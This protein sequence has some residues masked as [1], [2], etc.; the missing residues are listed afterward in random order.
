MARDGAKKP[1]ADQD[2]AAA[3]IS[4]KVIREDPADLVEV[5]PE[6]DALEIDFED[7]FGDG[8]ESVIVELIRLDPKFYAGQRV[9]GFLCHLPP[10]STKDTIRELYGGGQFRIIKKG[11]GGKIIASRG[12]AIAGV[13]FLPSTP[14]G[15]TDPAAADSGS[16]A[17]AHAPV[18]T[19]EGI[20][21]GIENAEFIRMAQQ[22]ALIRAA[23]PDPNADLIK[24]LLNRPAAAPQQDLVALAGQIIG[25]VNQF[26]EI[27][28][29]AAAG[30][31]GSGGA[32][33]MDVLKEGVAAFGAYMKAQGSRPAPVMS[34][35]ELGAPPRPLPAPAPVLLPNPEPPAAASE[36][37]TPKMSIQEFVNSA[38]I[39]LCNGYVMKKTPAEVVSALN[40]SIPL[41]VSA[42]AAFLEPQKD[43]FK[44]LCETNLSDDF[45]ENPELADRFPE[46][47]EQVFSG[48]IGSEKKD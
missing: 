1:A 36:S 14:G 25:L 12:V 33:L 2:P 9:G 48:F 13:P 28:P 6:S 18:L 27:M 16:P 35:P 23:F 19:K 41:P 21:I 15:R 7:L 8:S 11:I 38:I 45:F 24:A 22:L 47:F 43:A 39:V 5:D 46:F 34:R 30:D 3:K 32:G 20:P 42:R 40:V 31:S 37:E 4:D 26:K 17:A 44:T 10:G 29:T